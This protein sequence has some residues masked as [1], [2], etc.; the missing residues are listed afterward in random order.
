MVD[1]NG[2]SGSQDPDLG[3]ILDDLIFSGQRDPLGKIERLMRV[4]S[5]VL[6]SDDIPQ[7]HAG[8]ANGKG[9]SE[10]LALILSLA[11]DKPDILADHLANFAATVLDILMQRAEDP[12][13]PLESDRRFRDPLWSQSPV[14]RGLMQIYLAWGRSMQAWLAD[15]DLDKDDRLR[16]EFI[17]RQL[18]AAFSPTNLPL[19]PWAQEFLL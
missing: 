19:H 8:A 11:I 10:T 18:E 15:Q 13:E 3:D 12:P 1:S 6:Q 7:G 16:I 14:L 4:A 17:L 9:V 2:P 5:D